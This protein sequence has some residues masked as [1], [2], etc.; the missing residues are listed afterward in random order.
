MERVLDQMEEFGAENANEEICIKRARLNY[1]L[2]RSNFAK[3]SQMIQMLEKHLPEMSNTH[4]LSFLFDK[5]DFF[6]KRED[7]SEAKK[8]L[9]EMK[10]FR[11][12]YLS[13]S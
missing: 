3:A 9:H 13:A 10:N 1:A 11:K 12:F 7:F 2:F 5:F 8:T 4:K 6:I